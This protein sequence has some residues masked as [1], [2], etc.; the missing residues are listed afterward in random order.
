MP[1]SLIAYYLTMSAPYT[2][3]SAKCTKCFATFNQVDK[4]T[5][6]QGWGCATNL[7]FNRSM[8]GGS[9]DSSDFIFFCC[10]GSK[11]HHNIYKPCTSIT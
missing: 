5:P 4:N 2:K 11:Y 10:Y 3:G 6:H 7:D 9:Y 1:L 8:Y